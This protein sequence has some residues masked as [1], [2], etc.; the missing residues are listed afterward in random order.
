MSASPLH[1]PQPHS[2]RVG[3][4]RRELIRAGAWSA[5]VLVL[6]T[7]AP[8]AAAVSTNPP[9]PVLLRDTVYPEA[10]N[11]ASYNAGTL[12]VNDID[13]KY[14]YARWGIT[15]EAGGPATA[16]VSYRISILDGSRQVLGFSD[17]GPIVVEKY[18]S[19]REHG[20]VGNVPPGTYILQLTVTAVI[21]SQATLPYTFQA[22][23]PQSSESAPITV[24]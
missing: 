5:P 2:E 10:I 24:G 20:P 19:H 8:A 6:A 17:G 23:V 1:A 3:L 21:F 11:A 22:D 16:S 4:S 13:I 7:A 12:S 9:P 14:D 15:D 18:E